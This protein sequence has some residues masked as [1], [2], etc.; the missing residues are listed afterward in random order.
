MTRASSWLDRDP[1]ERIVRWGWTIWSAW[2]VIGGVLL[3]KDFSAG[4]GAMS[5]ILVAPFWG[6]WLAWPAYR[7]FCAAWRWHSESS[8][9]RWNGMYYEFDGRQIRILLQGEVI[10]IVAND[11]FDALVLRGRQRD[12]EHVRQIAG[13]DGLVRLPDTRLLAFSEVGIKAW[14]D[15]RTEIVAHKFSRWLDKQVI[16]PYRRRLEIEADEGGKNQAN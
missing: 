10:W 15:R 2:G 5:A 11:V 3:L 16:V 4:V 7:I 12:P 9:A 8:W 6:L 1:D 14:L 13:R